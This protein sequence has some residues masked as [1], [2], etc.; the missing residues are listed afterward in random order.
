M[1]VKVGRR[2]FIT[3]GYSPEVLDEQFVEPEFHRQLR[4]DEDAYLAGRADALTSAVELLRVHSRSA[5]PEWVQ[6][7][8]ETELHAL[9]DQSVQTSAKGRHARAATRRKDDAC[10]IIRATF[11]DCE[12]ILGL[13]VAAAYRTVS[14]NLR[15]D[16]GGTVKAFCARV[17]IDP[18]RYYPLVD[19]RAWRLF[20][21]CWNAPPKSAS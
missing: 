10:D 3:S 1:A 21:A 5:W 13:T 9:V 6:R 2:T 18:A 4:E 8:V 14:E 11:V 20:E 12:I 15:G 19:W 7:G 17:L 16:A